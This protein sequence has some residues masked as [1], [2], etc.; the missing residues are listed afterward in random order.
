MTETSRKTKTGMATKTRKTTQTG[1]NQEK[2]EMEQKGNRTG[3]TGNDT[4]DGN[5]YHYQAR[6]QSAQAR[7][8]CALTALG[9]FLA[10]GTPTVGG[11]KTF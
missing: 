3:R 8:A 5:D 10:D 4:E 6:A 7:R 2:L 11:G 9:L 1:T